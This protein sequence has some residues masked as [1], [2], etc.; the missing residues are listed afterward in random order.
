MLNSNGMALGTGTC[1]SLVIGL[2][3]SSPYLRTQ[4][5]DKDTTTWLTQ[6]IGGAG[7]CSRDSAT[8]FI[9]IHSACHRKSQM[10]SAQLSRTAG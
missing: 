8:A 1:R 2:D 5:S 7:H 6:H 10:Y 4:Y 9:D 3:K